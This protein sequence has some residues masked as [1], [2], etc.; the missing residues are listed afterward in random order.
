MNLFELPQK[1]SRCYN[2]NEPGEAADDAFLPRVRN[3]NGTIMQGGNHEKNNHYFVCVLLVIGL[4]ACGESGGENPSPNGY[5]RPEN[6]TMDTSFEAKSSVLVAYFSKTGTTSAVAET[7]AEYLGADLF[8][9]ERKEPYPDAYTPTTE[10]AEEE[11]EANA[12][13]ELAVYL[14]DEVMAEYDTILLGFPIWWHTAPMAVLSFLNYYDLSGKTVITFCTSGGS[15]I[16]ESTEDIRDNTNASVIEGQRFGKTDTADIE[17]WLDRLSLRTETPEEPSSPASQWG[18]VLVVYFSASGRTE[19]VAREIADAAGGDL[20]EL[21]PIDPY[22][23]AD[24]NYSDEDSRV[25]RE[26]REESLRDVALTDVTVE[27]WEEYETVLIGYPIWWG[28]AAWPVNGFVEANDFTGKTV[29]PFCTSASSG[30]GESGTLLEEAAGTGN[31]LEGVRFRSGAS[32]SD[33]RAWWEGLA[34]DAE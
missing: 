18:D 7:I 4:V 8:E 24:L 21:V 34:P 11:K 5:K 20:F 17:N 28:I 19:A 1:T 31:W 2:K 25:S 15:A 9:I 27:N 16:S 29:I 3:E 33:V 32:A 14:P 13:P 12:R 23:S 30:L 26:Y 22:T 10:E 6:P